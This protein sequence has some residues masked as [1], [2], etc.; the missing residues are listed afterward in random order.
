MLMDYP[1]I[2]MQIYMTKTTVWFLIQQVYVLVDKKIL[3]II[4][5]GSV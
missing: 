5:L 3:F 1:L 4:Y 2:S